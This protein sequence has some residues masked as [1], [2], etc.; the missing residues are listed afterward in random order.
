M[1]YGRPAFVAQ[2]PR[3]P[4]P[5]PSPSP[6]ALNLRP[7]L[8]RG[9]GTCSLT[10]LN[11]SRLLLQLR[12]QVNSFAPIRILHVANPSYFSYDSSLDES[13]ADQRTATRGRKTLVSATTHTSVTILSSSANEMATDVGGLLSFSGKAWTRSFWVCDAMDF[14]GFYSY[15]PATT[16]N[17]IFPLLRDMD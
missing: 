9:M 14:R 11:F 2:Q 6:S 1:P 13:L 17:G 4:S 8:T 10:F 7:S 16:L 15:Q 5:S 12:Q 3:P